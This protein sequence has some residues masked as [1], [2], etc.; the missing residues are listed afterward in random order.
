MSD[1]NELD[2]LKQQADT[3]GISYHPSI[4]L[5]KLKEKVA[6]RLQ[7][8]QTSSE[9]NKVVPLTASQ[10]RKQAR[11]KALKLIRIRLSCMDPAKS[12][13]SGEI[14]T[15]SNDVVG[16]VKRFIPYREDFYENGYHV[17]QIILNRL[18]E[19]KYGAIKTTKVNGRDNHITVMANVYNI[20]ILPP[21]SEEE[22]EALRLQQ[23]ASKSID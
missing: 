1:L 13:H 23:A 4:G 20:E 21:L 15:V 16:T 9:D 19:A 17:E 10:E 3:L 18:R 12:N 7:G 8:S 6:E 5:D 2:L 11:D 22:L 14:V